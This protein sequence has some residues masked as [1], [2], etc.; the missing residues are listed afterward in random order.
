MDVSASLQKNPKV[1]ISYDE[2]EAYLLLPTPA[3]DVPY[4]LDEIMDIIKVA[5]VKIGVDEAKIASMIEENENIETVCRFCGEKY[6]FTVDELK[7]ILKKTT[8]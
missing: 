1:R 4:K 8:R 2:M 5:G 6:I 7:E 3:Y